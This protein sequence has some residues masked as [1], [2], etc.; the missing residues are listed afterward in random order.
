M[1]GS[2]F[3]KLERPRQEAPDDEKPNAQGASLDRFGA[4]QAPARTPEAPEPPL[5]RFEADGSQGLRVDRH[6]DEEQPFTRCPVCEADWGR[7]ETRCNQCGEALDTDKAR[8]F[9][10]A[11]WSKRLAERAQEAKG[12]AER[13]AAQAK[14]QQEFDEARKGMAI[15]MA[16]QVKQRYQLQSAAGDVRSNWGFGARYGWRWRALGPVPFFILAAV[17]SAGPARWVFAAFAALGVGVSVWSW[18]KND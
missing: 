10:A 14:Q 3:D 12:E 8:A 15:A 6:T 1:S 11:L 9:N 17:R 7:F 5:E 13:A 4:P 16:Q 18:L 2:R